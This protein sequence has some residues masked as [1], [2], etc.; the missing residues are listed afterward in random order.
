MNKRT[1][2]RQVEGG[3]VR[4]EE[5]SARPEGD[6]TWAGGRVATI[7]L[8]P[9][10]RNLNT[11]IWRDAESIILGQVDAWRKRPINR[12]ETARTSKRSYFLAANVAHG[13]IGRLRVGRKRGFGTG[14]AIKTKRHQRR[15]IDIR[16]IREVQIK[17]LRRL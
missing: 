4:G 3:K 9:N 10:Q 11:R 1:G 15:R 13:R 6:G 2:N 5:V 17:M 14:S 7:K 12:V 16:Q 8:E